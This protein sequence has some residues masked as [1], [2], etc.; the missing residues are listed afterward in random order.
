MEYELEFYSTTEGHCPLTDW[1]MNLKDLQGRAKIKL[2]LDRMSL[3][4]FGD[5]E[6]VGGGVS[7]LKIHFGPGY[8]IYFGRIGLKCILLLCGGNKQTQ[9]NDIKKA[10]DLFE[11]YKLRGEVYAKRK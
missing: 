1:L 6:G 9:G 10:K 2:R 7:E 11:E 4:N 8:R 3:G 5:C